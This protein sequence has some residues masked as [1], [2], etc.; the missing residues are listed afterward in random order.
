MNSDYVAM[1]VGVMT[2]AP[3][4][5]SHRDHKHPR[6]AGAESPPPRP[7]PVV[8]SIS[9]SHS[10]PSLPPKQPRPLS[11][12]SVPKTDPIEPPQPS[13]LSSSSSLF[14]GM[15]SFPAPPTQAVATVP[16]RSVS[17]SLPTAQQRSHVRTA[18]AADAK[19][20]IPKTESDDN[21]SNECAVCL[22]RPPDC[23]LYMCGHMCMCYNCALGIHR[24][25][26][27]SCPICRRPILDI[28]KIFRT[29]LQIGMFRPITYSFG[30]FQPITY[31]FTWLLV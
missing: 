9:S 23:V 6:T 5:L 10:P 30:M 16:R 17:A 24:S 7:P 28:I 13:T 4:W 31:S 15:T 18:S 1:C 22:E 20:S 11:H 27:P 14:A 8:R 21:S 29:W 19:T 25:D 3:Q 12:H 2:G 26:D